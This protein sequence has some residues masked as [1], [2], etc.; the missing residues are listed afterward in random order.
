MVLEDFKNELQGF[1]TEKFS[2]DFFLGFSSHQKYGIQNDG[3]LSNSYSIEV[4]KKVSN[5]PSELKLEKYK[6]NILL[7]KELGIT[8]FALSLSWEE[9]LPNGDGV[10]DQTKIA[11][12]HEV[13]DYCIANEIEPFVTLFDFNLPLAIEEKGGWLNREILFW[14]EN[15]VA[16]CVTTFKDKVNHW[17]VINQPSVL[18]ELNL[19]IDKRSISKVNLNKFLPTVHHYLLCQSIGFKKIKQICPQTQV[20][21]IFSCHYV[22]SKTILEKDIKATERMDALLNKVFLEPTLGLGYPIKLMPSLKKIF[23]YFQFGDSDLLKVDFD[24]IS[25]NKCSSEVVVYDLFTSY[26]NARIVK[27]GLINSNNEPLEFELYTKLIYQIINKYSKYEG[28]KKIFIIE[29]N[30]SFFEKTIQ[31]NEDQTLMITQIKTFLQQISNAKKSGG[32]V[33]GFFVSF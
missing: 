5:H 24:F 8:N 12:Y 14:F 13:L 25:I 1:I 10:I 7:S 9:I 6:K 33:D 28:I 20:G 3:F 4:P 16:I 19:F 2:N 11:F 22:T 27:F 26:I 21:T 17:I 23:K 18:N 31:L 29:N 32:K 15:Y 30:I